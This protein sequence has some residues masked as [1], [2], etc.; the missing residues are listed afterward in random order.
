MRKYSI[1][2]G[3]DFGTTYSKVS[4]GERRIV[5]PVLF[6]IGKNETTKTTEVFY[7]PED[8]IL[9]YEKLKNK[10][11]MEIIKYFKYSF[12]DKSLPTSKHLSKISLQTAPEILCCVFFLACLIGKTKNYIKEYYKAK[13]IDII[14][15]WN[16]NMGV[17][18]DN[19]ESDHKSLYDKIL[20][21][22]VKLSNNLQGDKANIKV[23]IY[24]LDRFVSKEFSLNIPKHG[25]SPYNTL[26]ELYAL[27]LPFL[28]DRNVPNGIY[29][30][31]D[32]GGATVD[33]AVFLKESQESFSIVAKDIQ[34]LGVEMLI[35]KGII[36][37]DNLNENFFIEELRVMFA[38]L[39][40]E[41]KGK[42]EAKEALKNQKGV[43]KII[44]CGGGAIYKCFEYSVLE[45]R[46][47]IRNT[48]D[49]SYKLETISIEK[50]LELSEIKNHRLL[51][52]KGL[53]QRIEDIPILIGFPWHFQKIEIQPIEKSQEKRWELEDIQREKYGEVL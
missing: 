11:N 5:N 19:F 48:L 53:A 32:I 43:L 33:I 21:A 10:P 35:N 39:A 4:F 51:I 12:I 46:S 45:N 30:I 8:N 40:M 41:V 52:S 23:G 29:A 20:H 13:N 9:H 34:P 7:D 25:E 37:Q 31:V 28:Q 49:I 15:E 18:I 44:I 50:L 36:K 16:I 38:K 26:S 6:G 47:Y 17:P 24:A 22:S 27:C 14:P 1:N 2:I 3:L 42:K